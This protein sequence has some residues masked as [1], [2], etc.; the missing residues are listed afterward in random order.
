MRPMCLL[1]PSCTKAM[2][3]TT[4]YCTFWFDSRDELFLF[5]VVGDGKKN[6]F[7]NETLLIS[8]LHTALWRREA[9]RREAET[10]GASSSEP[11]PVSV[12]PP[13]PAVSMR[14]DHLPAQLIANKPLQHRVLNSRPS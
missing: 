3:F 11:F 12:I 2:I 8:I 13:V 1:H 7:E 5:P 6:H 4:A 9:E 14:P 10:T